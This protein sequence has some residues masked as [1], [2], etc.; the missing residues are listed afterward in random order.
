MHLAWD[1]IPHYEQTLKS[2]M[3]QLFKEENWNYIQNVMDDEEL[4]TWM[5]WENPLNPIIMIYIFGF[6]MIFNGIQYTCE[7]I[8]NFLKI[9]VLHLNLVNLITP[10]LYSSRTNTYAWHKSLVKLGY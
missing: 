9:H 5:L 7:T 2:L 8:I 4:S 6:I 1:N 3:L 10:I